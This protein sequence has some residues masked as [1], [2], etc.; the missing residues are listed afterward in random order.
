MP[1]HSVLDQLPI[2]LR[3]IHLRYHL[4]NT[5][6]KI[7]FHSVIFHKVCTAE[8]FALS[9]QQGEKHS[10]QQPNFYHQVCF[11]KASCYLETQ[12]IAA[13]I[14][15][16]VANPM[17]MRANFSTPTEANSSSDNSTPSLSRPAARAQNIS[18]AKQIP[19]SVSTLRQKRRR[20]A[21]ANPSQMCR[22][23]FSNA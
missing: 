1:C 21:N 6:Q 23:C 12:S 20:S 7:L 17:R 5:F 22:P 11:L 16:I 9:T 13:G 10:P 2:T 8:L 18:A 15:C 3:Q 19:P 4:I 14:S